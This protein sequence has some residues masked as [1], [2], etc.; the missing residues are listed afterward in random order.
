MKEKFE[1]VYQEVPC[2]TKYESLDTDSSP[3]A[4]K[5]QLITVREV[6]VGIL[7]FLSAI[8]VTC[9]CLFV[10]L[11]FEAL[12][13][14]PAEVEGTSSTTVLLQISPTAAIYSQ[15][16]TQ[17]GKIATN[18]ESIA[19][20]LSADPPDEL[21]AA[22]FVESVKKDQGGIS[23]L[24]PPN[25]VVTQALRAS[26]AKILSNR[27]FSQRSSPRH[28]S[29]RKRQLVESTMQEIE[30]DI[31]KLYQDWDRSLSK[32]IKE[33]VELSLELA[34]A[35]MRRDLPIVAHWVKPGETFVEDCMKMSD[36]ST[37]QGTVVL[38]VFPRWVDSEDVTI[39]KAMVFCVTSFI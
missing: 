4:T 30:R 16:A 29:S 34:F 2:D 20:K 5:P 11:A 22:T 26:I 1:S 13:S 25:A 7:W 9:L 15:I 21:R 8:V 39:V 24:L 28:S 27:V 38:C 14:P 31:S 19:S 23:L 32:N 6:P 18:I 35:T 33:L 17:L 10:I 36:I 12:G 3:E 37:P